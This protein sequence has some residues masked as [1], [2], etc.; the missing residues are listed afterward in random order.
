M[1]LDSSCEV[2]HVKRAHIRTKLLSS[3]LAVTAACTAGL[4]VRSHWRVD[5]LNWVRHRDKQALCSSRG[6]LQYQAYP[7]GGYGGHR[8]FGRYSW[9]TPKA[10]VVEALR[11]AGSVLGFTLRWE[12]PAETW[13]EPPAFLPMD[14]GGAIPGGSCPILVPVPG[15]VTR[16]GGAFRPDPE[17]PKKDQERLVPRLRL[18]LAGEQGAVPG[19][20][21]GDWTT[22]VM[23]W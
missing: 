21:A 18:R 23:A 11:P 22:G 14:Q 2:C 4:W 19:M 3:V 9:P 10:G 12:K 1:G 15:S 5:F 8:G 6:R 13:E 17:I 16:P 20:W 7:Y